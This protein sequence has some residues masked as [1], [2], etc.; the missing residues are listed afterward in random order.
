[1]QH[2]PLKFFCQ[3]WTQETLWYILWRLQ[4]CL[5]NLPKLGAFRK[6]I[7]SQRRSDKSSIN[8]IDLMWAGDWTIWWYHFLGGV[9]HLREC[10]RPFKTD[11]VFEHIHN[12]LK[13]TWHSLIWSR[14]CPWVWPM[15]FYTPWFGFLNMSPI[16]HLLGQKVPIFEM[17]KNSTN[18]WSPPNF[19]ILSH[20]F[21]Q[22]CVNMWIYGALSFAS[23][24][25]AT[26]V[27]VFWQKINH[28]FT[29][30]KVNNCN[31]MSFGNL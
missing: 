17:S 9:T 6:S 13:G 12:S 4:G 31:R 24:V 8:L 3:I 21:A 22:I 7:F 16:G 11:N 15:V 10:H 25:Q 5:S 2:F 1:M 29:T 18:F 19:G 27:W 28:P 26:A 20:K 14:I 23:G 30:W